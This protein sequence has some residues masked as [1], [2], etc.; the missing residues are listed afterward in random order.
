MSYHDEREIE[1]DATGKPLQYHYIGFVQGREVDYIGTVRK[2]P[3][4]DDHK[5]AFANHF[6]NRI[7]Q[8]QAHAYRFLDDRIGHKDKPDESK[9]HIPLSVDDCVHFIIYGGPSIENRFGVS[10]SL[11]RPVIL[12]HKVAMNN[13]HKTVQALQ[14]TVQTHNKSWDDRMEDLITRLVRE[15]YEQRNPMS[16][17]NFIKNRIPFA[18]KYAEYL[19]EE[20]K[21]DRID[22]AYHQLSG[23]IIGASKTIEQW[24]SEYIAMH[25]EAHT[26]HK[27]EQALLNPR[28]DKPK[29]QSVN[30]NL[31]RYD[32]SIA[33]PFKSKVRQF[34][35]SQYMKDHPDTT[36]AVAPVQEKI[37]YK[38]LYRPCFSDEPGSWEID[39]CFNMAEPGDSWLFCVNVNTRYLIAYE[40]DETAFDVEVALHNLCETVKRQFPKNLVKSIRGDGSS[41]YCHPEWR[42][43]VYDPDRLKVTVKNKRWAANTETKSLMNWYVNNKMTI[44]FND[45]KFTL[46]NKIIDVAIKTIRNAIGYRVITP[47]K[48][49]QIIDY[50]NNTVHKSIGCTPLEMQS[51]IE[52]EHQYIRYCQRVLGDVLEQQQ[53]NGL[54][55]YK[56]GNILKVHVDTGKTASKMIKRR[57]FY[58][59]L[60][61][62]IRY[63]H[64]NVVVRLMVPINITKTQERYE[65]TV[66]VWHTKFVAKDSAS[67]PRDVKEFYVMKAYRADPEEN[68]N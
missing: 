56:P 45:G 6:N 35:K 9:W 50:Y 13:I 8:Y 27:Q 60:G 5:Q 46:H 47:G 18:K 28:P 20:H 37:D 11:W 40:C 51:N 39:H 23:Y 4:D 66:P 16:L 54:L 58:D 61:T 68:E 63:D 67:I 7:K 53:L 17:I 49:Q 31:K 1:Y 15:T 48:L 24:H 59:R 42:N 30:S 36:I 25:N 3:F 32:D 41:A 12:D 10:L 21:L 57:A 38:A 33:Y 62:F 14:E 64:G 55:Q 19:K 2:L 65:I 44:Y 22:T 43:S 34:K 52:L 29:K 26:S